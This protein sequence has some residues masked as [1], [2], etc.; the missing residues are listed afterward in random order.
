MKIF[1]ATFNPG[2]QKEFKRILSKNAHLKLYF[3]QDLEITEE[4]E[5]SGTTFEENSVL[6]AKFY[7]NLTKIP[8]LADDGGLEIHVLGG[9]P[10]VKTRRWLGYKVT[11]S[12]LID[13][14]LDKLKKYKN[15]KERRA[16]LRACMTYFDGQTI[17]TECEKIEGYIAAVAR[18]KKTPGYP[19]GALLMVDG[20]DKYYDDLRARENQ[21]VNHREKA[22]KRLWKRIRNVY[23]K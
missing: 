17:L 9:E 7:F 5:E 3:P 11:D 1:I 10:G 12:E 22:L 8:T 4:V 6:K 23:N 18:K 21:A 14:T 16:N 15:K 19:F 13:H 20:F 2:K